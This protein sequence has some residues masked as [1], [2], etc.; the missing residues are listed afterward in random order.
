MRKW[1]NM[2]W[3][4]LT[5]LA[6]IGIEPRLEIKDWGQGSYDLY[7]EGHR[8][9]AVDADGEAVVVKIASWPGLRL[10]RLVTLRVQTVTD[11]PQLRASLVLRMPAGFEDSIA[12][13]AS[14]TRPKPNDAPYVPEPVDEQTK[15]AWADNRKQAAFWKGKLHNVTSTSDQTGTAGITSLC[16]LCEKDT[17][18]VR[19]GH[20]STKHGK[21]W[22]EW[23]CVVC[24]TRKQL[25]N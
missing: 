12:P 25:P 5:R 23:R 21:D 17:T 6:E 7:F 22:L 1:P 2:G 4:A 10:D 3:A 15:Q 13:P 24:L 20:H 9:G 11:L 18:H 8:V 14:R 19:T 16:Q